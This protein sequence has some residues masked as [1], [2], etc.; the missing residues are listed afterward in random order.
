MQNPLH[1]RKPHYD[2]SRMYMHMKQGNRLQTI[3]SW[4]KNHS[5]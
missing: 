5:G 3:L 4:I 1:F 2:Q